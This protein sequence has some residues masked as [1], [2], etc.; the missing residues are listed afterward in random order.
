[1]NAGFDANCA[2]KGG[3]FIGG[4]L[5]NVNGMTF[6]DQ[7]GPFLVANQPTGAVYLYDIRARLNQVN[8]TNSHGITYNL[9]AMGNRTSVVTT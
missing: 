5:Q 7:G 4:S 6:I 2:Y 9:D 8:F 3:A 1:M